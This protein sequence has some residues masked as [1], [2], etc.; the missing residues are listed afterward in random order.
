MNKHVLIPAALALAATAG[1]QAQ[2][3]TLYGLIDAALQ[4]T[5]G[6]AGGHRNSL[7][8]GGIQGSRYGF[9]GSEDLGGGLKAVFDLENQFA[10]DTGANKSASLAFSRKADVGVS[11]SFG[12][13]TAG[14]HTIFSY[15]VQA[16]LDPVQ[17]ANFSPLGNSGDAP[18]V[19]FAD[20]QV[21]NARRDNSIKYSYEQNGITAGLLYAFGEVAG[22]TSAGSTLGARLGYGA[23]GFN[24]QAAYDQTKDG[25]GSN[26]ASGLTLGGTYTLGDVTGY[27]GW[28]EVKNDF[29][30]A[31]GFGRK[32]SVWWL[33]ARCQASKEL[34]LH[35][36][37]YDQKQSGTT[38]KT[39]AATPAGD[40]TAH[41]LS[42]LADY[43]LSK[44]T[45]V[46]AS[47]QH[48]SLKDGMVAAMSP[49]G[50]SSAVTTTMLGLRTKF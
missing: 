44:R 39:G 34:A 31:G 13:L 25:T 5:D 24:V 16:D 48:T 10:V 2:S 27:L 46:Y 21:V 14:R 50:V 29:H 33:G 6:V 42:L 15:D 22:S 19:Q 45:D 47:L 23:A 38:D 49:S 11:G 32:N 8:S 7:I 18:V 17:F 26:K 37:F 4:T 9:K 30:A 35:A 41:T 28:V 12:R 36:G 3:V 40:G 43:S 1:A 20:Y